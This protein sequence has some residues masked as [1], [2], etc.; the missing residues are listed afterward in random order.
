MKELLCVFAPSGLCLMVFVGQPGSN[1]M[2]YI[3][4]RFW[5]KKSNL[6]RPFFKKKNEYFGHRF[7]RIRVHEITNWKKNPFSNKSGYVWTRSKSKQKA[8]VYTY[9]HQTIVLIKARNRSLAFHPEKLNF[10]LAE[11]IKLHKKAP[12]LLFSVLFPAIEVSNP[13]ENFAT[14]H[15]ITQQ[16]NVHTIT[17]GIRL[18]RA[19]KFVQCLCCNTNICV[20]NTV[21]LNKT[22]VCLGNTN[23]RLGET[24]V[25][26]C[27]RNVFL[28]NTNVCPG[29][30]DVCLGNTSV[31]LG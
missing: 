1:F 16:T 14:R 4:Q 17:H 6:K 29:N 3:K 19:E 30:N 20:G 26:F 31:C 13:Q 22:I 2:T 21:C 27:N 15:L 9:N 10:S 11:S 7:R 18:I 28:G 24:Y 23:P 8:K 25:C 12:W 5:K